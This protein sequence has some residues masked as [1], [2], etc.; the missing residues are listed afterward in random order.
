M[1]VTIQNWN[2]KQKKVFK[3]KIKL[4]RSKTEVYH[5]S[6]HDLPRLLQLQRMTKIPGKAVNKIQRMWRRS[7]WTR[8]VNGSRLIEGREWNARQHTKLHWTA[9]KNSV[10][11]LGFFFFWNCPAA[12]EHVS[13]WLQQ[14]LGRKLKLFRKLARGST[15]VGISHTLCKYQHFTQNTIYVAFG[16]NSKCQHD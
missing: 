10:L 9:Q 11:A 8:E 3:N 1:P 15:R 6:T 7:K 16:F 2:V 4:D 5:R 13:Y 12:N 14:D